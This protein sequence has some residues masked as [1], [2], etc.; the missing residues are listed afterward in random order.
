[1]HNAVR[2]FFALYHHLALPGIGNLT[3]QTS[4]AQ[5]DF[6]NRNIIPS[7]ACINFSNDGI[8]PDKS[9]YS[10]LSQELQID[11][12][13]AEHQFAGFTSSLRADLDEQKTIR[14]RGIGQL[15]KQSSHIVN[16]QPEEK[17]SN[18]YF[19]PIVAERVIRKNAAHF[20]KVGEQEKTSTE[21]QTVLRQEEKKVYIEP[22]R[23]RWW[24]PAAILAFIGVIGIFMYYVIHTS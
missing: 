8:M 10:F 2:K 12:Q 23:E 13:Q 5:L 21:M 20:I 14:L 6:V 22:P 24:I 9:F 15:T 19:P 1:M 16:F 18:G 11:E 17:N 3:L 4:P 7:L